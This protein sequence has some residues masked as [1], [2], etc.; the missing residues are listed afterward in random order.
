M[1]T[2]RCISITVIVLLVAIS[3]CWAYTG[4][5]RKFSSIR[6]SVTR[7]RAMKQ[8]AMV[9]PV[10]PQL[11]GYEKLIK[12]MF[13]YVIRWYISKIT[14]EGVH[15]EAVFVEDMTNLRTTYQT[16]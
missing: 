9:L 15:V 2:I 3:E 1:A 8:V 14:Q 7:M 13:P 10:Q 12:K 16:K 11:I 6:S 5:L 4:H